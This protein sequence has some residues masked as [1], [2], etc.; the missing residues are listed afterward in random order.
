[1][2]EGE[3]R[4]SGGRGGGRGS[5]LIDGSKGTG[6]VICPNRS[7]K[8]H[9]FPSPRPPSHQG[10][11]SASTNLMLKKEKEPKEKQ[12]YFL[13]VSVSVLLFFSPSD[14][15]CT[16]EKSCLNIKCSSPKKFPSQN[17]D[18]IIDG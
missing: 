13:F 9:L 7:H 11:S 8:P 17:R 16:T 15:V 4:G 5:V 2:E 18:S 3:K 12:S 1:M 6:L 14:I 10:M